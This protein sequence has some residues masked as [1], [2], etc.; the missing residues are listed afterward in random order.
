MESSKD[1]SLVLFD[2]P[3]NSN[4][5][6]MSEL[7]KLQKEFQETISSIQKTYEKKVEKE[8][9][10]VDSLEKELE[11]Y[12]E[13]VS[14]LDKKLNSIAD[15]FEDAFEYAL[16]ETYTYK[17]IEHFFGEKRLGKS[18]F[19]WAFMVWR[20]ILGPQMRLT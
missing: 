10:K 8:Q 12:K 18:L 7:S 5:E 3:P 9:K 20:G 16:L 19:F 15:A 17:N 13:K 6:I 2:Q 4:E 11:F 1:Q 14:S